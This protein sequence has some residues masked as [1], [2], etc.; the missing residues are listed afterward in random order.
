MRRTSQHNRRNNC[1][2]GNLSLTETRIGFLTIRPCFSV[3]RLI[4]LLAF[5]ASYSFGFAGFSA[6]EEVQ[7]P[8][9][10]APTA[11]QQQEQANNPDQDKLN[12]LYSILLKSEDGFEYRTEGRPDPFKPFVTDKQVKE[13]QASELEELTGMRRFEPGQL[14]LVAIVFAKEGPLAMVEDSVGKGYVLRKGMKIGRA[15]EII[16]IISSKVLIKESYFSLTQQLLYKNIEMVLR[17]E[18]EK[19]Q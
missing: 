7:A 2:M 9:P 16:D 13:E 10:A 18:G 12:K 17:K 1:P 6:A 8:Q 5:C 11:N 19:K 14:T 15:G 3:A 4:C